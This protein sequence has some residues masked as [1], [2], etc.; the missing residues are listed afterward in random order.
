M[1]RYRALSLKFHPGT[2][3][4]CATRAHLLH[5]TDKNPG[6]EAAAKKFAE[7]ANAYEILSN[8]DKRQIYDLHGEEGLKQQNQPANPFDF[9]GQQRGG[10][11]KGPDF[12]MDFQGE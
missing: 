9:F 5:L 11:R 8:P 12:R 10:M 2:A 4:A 3:F 1:R 6:D 7:I